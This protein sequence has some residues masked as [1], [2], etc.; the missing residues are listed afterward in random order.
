VTIGSRIKNLR[1]SKSILQRELAS[2]LRI[3]EG[4]LSKIESNQKPIKR[5]HLE[6]LSNILDASSE[7]LESLWLAQKIIH[8]LYEEE[9]ALSA[10]KLAEAEIEY[11]RSKN[12]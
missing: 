2:Q 3:S 9:Q 5:E 1:E 4:Y 7:E 10:I 6:I 12:E 8:L 11:K